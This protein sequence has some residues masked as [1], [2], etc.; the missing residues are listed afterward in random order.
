MPEENEKKKKIEETN[1][2]PDEILTKIT[3]KQ[4]QKHSTWHDK[5][6]RRKKKL[7][8]FAKAMI[9]KIINKYPEHEW[10]T[11]KYS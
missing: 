1:N 3:R 7:F 5:A 2:Y 10:L 8:L 4:V 9:N 6:K 11:K